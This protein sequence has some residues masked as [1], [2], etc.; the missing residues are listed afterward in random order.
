MKFAHYD[1]ID[2]D[3][4]DDSK[5][6]RGI[7]QYGMGS[8]EAIKMDPSF[9]ISEKILPNDGSKPQAKHLQAR[10]EYLLKILRKQM[11][12]DDNLVSISSAVIIILQVTHQ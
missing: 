7:Y 5:L 2:W 10:A 9:G 4:E 3:I 8:W 12:I 6:L 1:G 11:N